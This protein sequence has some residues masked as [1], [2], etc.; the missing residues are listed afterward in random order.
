M[1]QAALLERLCWTNTQNSFRECVETIDIPPLINHRQFKQ[2]IYKVLE[3]IIVENIGEGVE[4]CH[5]LNK[6]SNRTIV[7]F[8]R[9][10][11]FESY[12]NKPAIENSHLFLKKVSVPY[13][14]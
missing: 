13:K 9:R 3:H 8:S 7:K 12:V 1:K 14:L 11:D 4:S 2:T 10:K 5:S 6:K